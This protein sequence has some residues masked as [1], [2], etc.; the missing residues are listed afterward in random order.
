MEQLDTHVKSQIE[1]VGF[2]R[3]F[4]DHGTFG[5]RK[6]KIFFLVAGIISLLIT[7][8]H[9]SR[10]WSGGDFT[11]NIFIYGALSMIMFFQ[12]LV[13]LHPKNAPRIE[14]YEDHLLI[15]TKPF[16]SATTFPWERISVLH[17]WSYEVAFTLTDGSHHNLIINTE[18]T[19]ISKKIKSFLRQLAMQKNVTIDG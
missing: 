4:L 17:L 2:I 11:V 5:Y 3:I 6:M 16:K 9:W 12:G 7:L 13:M 8:L 15:K 14:I 10:Y 1:E 19:E 18:N